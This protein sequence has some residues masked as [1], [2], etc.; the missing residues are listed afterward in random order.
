MSMQPLSFIHTKSFDDDFSIVLNNIPEIC[1]Y[2]SA[3]NIE[4]YMTV[5]LNFKRIL[6]SFEYDVCGAL[7]Q[8]KKGTYTF[9]INDNILIKLNEQIP[10]EP[11]NWIRNV[12]L[13]V[14]G[15]A[16]KIEVPNGLI[17]NWTNSRSLMNC[18]DDIIYCDNV[19][20][21]RPRENLI[22]EAIDLLYDFTNFAEW[23]ESDEKWDYWEY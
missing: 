20:V 8:Y 19:F 11:S 7:P 2:N 6:A 17:N 3:F 23:K 22:S 5:L 1:P 10:N 16:F 9:I 14:N 21:E 4:S 15:F 18:Y 12:V 13:H